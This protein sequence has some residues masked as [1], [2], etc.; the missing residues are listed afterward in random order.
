MGNGGSLLW[1]FGVEIE[2]LGLGGKD[3]Y[4][5]VTLGSVKGMNGED[6]SHVSW[7]NLYLA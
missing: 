1:V 4:I 6:F 3:A 2:L 5:L 7:V